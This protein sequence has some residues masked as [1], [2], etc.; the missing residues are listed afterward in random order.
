M[1]AQRTLRY[2]AVQVGDEL[3]ELLT[4]DNRSRL[5]VIWAE[6]VDQSTAPGYS[7]SGV[8]VSAARKTEPVALAHVVLAA[9]RVFTGSV[10]SAA[11]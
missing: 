7:I 5:P 2:S 10:G 3:E 6:F 1:T 11:G 9:R 4:L 8:R